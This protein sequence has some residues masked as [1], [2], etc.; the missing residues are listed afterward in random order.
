M[1]KGLVL[2]FDGKQAAHVDP[3]SL[4]L[5]EVDLEGRTFTP[6]DSSASTSTGA[7]VTARVDHPAI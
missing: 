3:Y 6:L 7:K 2:E 5:F 1:P 4:A